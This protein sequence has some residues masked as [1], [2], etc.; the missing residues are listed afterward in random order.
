MSR[1]GLSRLRPLNFAA[2]EHSYDARVESG[3]HRREHRQVWAVPVTVMGELHQ[4][5]QWVGLKTI[6]MVKRSPTPLEQDHP[7][8]DGLSHVV[9]L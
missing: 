3:H 4:I 8:D 7:R 5:E 2:L 9:A 6:V 1:R